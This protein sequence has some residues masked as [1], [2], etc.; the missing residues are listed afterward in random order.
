MDERLQTQPRRPQMMPSTLQAYHQ[1]GITLSERVRLNKPLRVDSCFPLSSR[2]DT[3]MH[4]VCLKNK[5]KKRE[6]FVMG[7]QVRK[8][9]DANVISRQ[10]CLWA[11]SVVRWRCQPH[12]TVTLTHDHPVIQTLDDVEG[13]LDVSFQD[14]VDDVRGVRVRMVRRCRGSQENDFWEKRITVVNT[15]V[16]F[17]ATLRFGR[18]RHQG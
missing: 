14:V 17:L 12:A 13:V 15:L 6:S 5:E 4:L 3:H 9:L 2:K 7:N 16:N 18:H 1:I 10:G 11:R 8:P